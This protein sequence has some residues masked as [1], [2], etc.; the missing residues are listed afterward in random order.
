M[1]KSKIPRISDK[2]RAILA[3]EAIQVKLLLEACGGR[4]MICGK[5]VGDKNLHKSHTRNRRR[6]V[7]SCYECHF[8]ENRHK[9]LKDKEVGNEKLEM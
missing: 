5:W 1:K 7:M 2:R 8:P 3:R 4:C 6:F 9:Y